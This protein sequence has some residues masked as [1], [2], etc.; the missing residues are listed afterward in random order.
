MSGLLR[1]IP[2]AHNDNGIEAGYGGD[3]NAGGQT[4]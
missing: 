1:I 2:I 3:M 4:T